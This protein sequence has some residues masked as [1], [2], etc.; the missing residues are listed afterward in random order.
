VVWRSAIRLTRVSVHRWLACTV[1]E[2]LKPWTLLA[3]RRGGIQAY[4]DALTMQEQVRRQ[5]LAPLE[6]GP[7]GRLA[8]ATDTHAAGDVILPAHP[9]TGG[10]RELFDTIMRTEARDPWR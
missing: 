9:L 1:P 7:L 6:Q 10:E 5:N 4:N 8:A 3:R 2:R